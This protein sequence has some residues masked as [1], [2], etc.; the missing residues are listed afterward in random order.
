MSTPAPLAA[1]RPPFWATPPG[2]GVIVLLL[3]LPRLAFA[4]R[5]GLIGD[6]AY[7]AIWSFYPSVWYYDHSP[8]VAWL[9]WLGRA[10][11]GESELA[12]R[13]MFFVADL[14]V[15]AALYRMGNILFGDR[16]IGA[17]AAIA[18]SVTIGVVI[19]FAVATPDGPSTMFWVL[20]VW[21]VAEFTRSRNANWWLLAGLCAGLG[22]LSKYTVVF[23]GAGLLVYLVTSRER[24]A[25]LK[26]WQVW[27]GG[28]LALLCFA[29][30]VWVNSQRDWNSFRYQLG[31]SN[32]ADHVVQ[33]GEFLRFLVEEGIQLLPTLYVF[34]IVGIVLFFA[35]RA[36][37]LG[38][39][40]LT[41][42]PMAAYFLADA[43]FGRVNPNW[44]A[45]L[46]PQLALVGAW[47]AITVRPQVG[48][49]R[50]ALNAIA[51]LHVPLGLALMFVAYQS[52]ETRTL[53]FLGPVKAFDFVYGWPD[54]WSKVSA[55]A[56]DS[57]ARW[58]DT[59]NYSLNG[60]LGYY[61][62]MAHD[63]LPVFETSE[64]FRYQYMPP[65]DP[66]LMAAPH[67]L[68]TPGTGAPPANA[69]LL[70]TVTRDAGGDPL[71]TYSV[72]LVK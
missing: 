21:A 45:P 46:F 54:L 52:I 36:R 22:L 42:T 48:W 25:W 32:F 43:L 66:V 44:T 17:V 47:A 35:R 9:I 11:L 29:P 65:A 33:P 53:P 57:G 30:V 20:A 69:T 15:C 39:P 67:L 40:V 38:L 58:V 59:T 72:Y 64:P 23:L 2:A 31:R 12:V 68:V 51:A 8:S 18:Y 41:A 37:S 70:A 27:A 71:E 62:R 34:V 55:L 60:W 61:A 49:L 14:V 16:R 13:S 24:L 28:A 4:I 19:T 1:P 26:L 50:W 6:E 5:F 10:L 3:T 63:P 56:K 7:Y